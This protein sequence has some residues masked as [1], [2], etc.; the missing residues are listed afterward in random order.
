MGG[1]WQRAQCEYPRNQPEADRVVE[2]GAGDVDDGEG[3]E[4]E[5]EGRGVTA[6]T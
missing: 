2:I 1:I 5:G 4:A 6:A 3:V